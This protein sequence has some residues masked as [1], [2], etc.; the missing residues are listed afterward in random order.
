M[1]ALHY[2]FGAL[3]LKPHYSL[4]IVASS[5]NLT[6]LTL[7]HSAE[8]VLSLCSYLNFAQNH[9][10]LTQKKST[11]NTREI[12]HTLKMTALPGTSVSDWIYWV[13]V[14]HSH[15]QKELY[16]SLFFVFIKHAE[17][18]CSTLKKILQKNFISLS[19]FTVHRKNKI[20]YQNAELTRS[21]AVQLTL[22]KVSIT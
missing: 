8:S 5:L 13:Q 9:A 2:I 7:Y 3:P 10:V 16:E 19:V 14:T 15:P 11:V 18:A 6:E 17:K 22:L 20:K 4:H 1:S 12:I 21:H